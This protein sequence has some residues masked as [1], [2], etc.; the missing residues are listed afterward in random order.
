MYAACASSTSVCDEDFSPI[1][2]DLGLLASGLELVFTLSQ[3][4]DPRDLN[5]ALYSDRTD[6]SFIRDLERDVDYSF[7]ATRNAIVFDAAHIPPAETYILADY[8]ILAD[9]SQVTEESP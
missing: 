9:G 6:D 5:V 2:S 1:A 4:A 7:D 8:R 3:L